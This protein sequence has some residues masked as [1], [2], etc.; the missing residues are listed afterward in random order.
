MKK[1]I[2]KMT[3]QYIIKLCYSQMYANI[4]IMNDD[5]TYWCRSIIGGN[6]T[7]CIVVTKYPVESTCIM[8]WH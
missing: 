1:E 3:S 8:E 5:V 2:N 7:K 6:Q 4:G